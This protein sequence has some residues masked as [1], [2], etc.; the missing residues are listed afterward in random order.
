MKDI[1]KLLFVSSLIIL[2]IAVNCISLL[3]GFILGVEYNNNKIQEIGAVATLELKTNTSTY[4][5]VSPYYDFSQYSCIPKDGDYKAAFVNRIIDGDTIEVTINNE[6]YAV[7]YI[8]IDT[9]EIGEIGFDEAAKT[10]SELVLNKTVVLIRDV[11]DKDRYNRLL[12]Y[13]VTESDFINYKIVS[14]GWAK[15]TPYTPDV[16]CSNYFYEAEEKSARLNLGLWKIETE[17]ALAEIQQPVLEETQPPVLEE[18]A[19]EEDEITPTLEME[20]EVIEIVVIL[21]D[22]GDGRRE[23]DEY[24][25]IENKGSNSIDLFNWKL[26]DSQDHIFI[27]PNYIIEPGIL[28][29]IYTNQVNS[30]SC[31]FSYESNVAIWNND[32]DCATLKNNSDEIVHQYCYDH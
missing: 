25:E 6:K 26:S 32:K 29:R 28:C 10:N 14:S 27:F 22:G 20:E 8:G 1:K 23:S 16:S 3:F 9:P 2:F 24:V 15:A 4:P 30:E 11:S 7:R 12:R 21:Y 31:G 18:V 17:Q 13:V 19:E 5:V